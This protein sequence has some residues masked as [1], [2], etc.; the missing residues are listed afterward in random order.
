MS[1]SLADAL[2]GTVPDGV[3]ALDEADQDRLRALLVR[4][5]DSQRAALDAAIEG[6]LNHIPRAL[7]AVVRRA[8]FR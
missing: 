1:S 6:G 3:K 8:L 4:A 2:G 7:R 5:G